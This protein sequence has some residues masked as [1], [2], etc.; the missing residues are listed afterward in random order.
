M[1]EYLILKLDVILSG[2]V[3]QCSLILNFYLLCTPSCHPRLSAERQKNL[4]ACERKCIETLIQ[5]II[6]DH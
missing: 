3:V 1:K 5:I 6:T 2:C 4:D